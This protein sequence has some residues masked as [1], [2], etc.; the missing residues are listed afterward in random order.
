MKK[1]FWI[2]ILGSFGFGFSGDPSVYFPESHRDVYLGMH[3]DSLVKLKGKGLEF[4]RAFN[5]LPQLKD[6]PK[7]DTLFTHTLYLFTADSLLYEIIIDYKDHFEL[8]RFMKD[9]YGAPNID[10]K[11][12]LIS[13]GDG[14]E[15]YIWEYNN[16]WCIA[17][18]DTYR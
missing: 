14:R 13:L 10:N 8:Y 3:M 18:G 15:L 7:Q 6:Y 11:E 4:S 2:L 12:W 17:D 9:F 1:L 5:G 16:R